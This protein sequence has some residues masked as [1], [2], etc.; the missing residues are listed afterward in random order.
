MPAPSLN[1]TTW[2]ELTEL[3]VETTGER[4]IFVSSLGSTETAPAALACTWDFDRPGNIGLPFP[5]VELKL[6]P[7]AASWKRACA[8]RISRPAIGGR[9]STPR[10]AFDDEGFYKIG[11]ALKF[12]DPDDPGKGMLFDGRIAEDFKLSTGTW[13]SVGPLRA[14]FVDHFA[15]YVRDVV[16]AGADRDDIAALV[17]PDIEACRKL[18]GLGAEA[19]PAAIVDAPNGARQ[20]RRIARQHSQRQAQGSST[21]VMRL[22]LMAEPPSLDKAEMTD[23]GSI[24]QRAV[25]TSRAGARRAALRRAFA[26]HGDYNRIMMAEPA[27]AQQTAPLRQIKVGPQEVDVEHRADGSMLLRSPQ[28][29]GP[30]PNKITERL[31]YWAE[32][33]P[34]R[35]LFA[36]R[37][38]SGAWR[39]VS[40]A[41]ALQQA[42]AIG[43]ALLERNLSPERPIAILS[44]NDIE[45]ALLGLGA[46]YAGIPYAPISPAY[47]LVSTDFG[48]LALHLRI[49]H[50]GPG[51]RRRRQC[52]RARHSKRGAG[53]HR[54][55]ADAQSAC[56]PRQPGIRQTHRHAH[57]ASMPRMTRSDPT[58]SPN[59]CSPRARP[60]CRNASSTRSACGARTR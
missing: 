46:I 60:A 18:A 11:D 35:T 30:Y 32:T 22:I 40:Y 31:V 19:T 1:Q 50:A 25:L 7:N 15:P 47:S 52:L 36:Q 4:I 57:R 3:A 29:L 16:F 2:D 12:A 53:R 9:T 49:D 58:P 41:Q 51:V 33:A 45:H 59:S 37:D 44:G 43:Q 27:R 39:T 38:A 6:V 8:G 17:F 26:E 55:G 56:R 20:L 24:N 48:R 34:D 23:K 14:R 13:V 54:S 5:G 21:R 42:R 10:D 28:P